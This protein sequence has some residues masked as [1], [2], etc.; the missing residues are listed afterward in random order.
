MTDQGFA[1]YGDKTKEEIN[2]TLYCP[3]KWAKNIENI[4]LSNSSQNA[5]YQ[6][7]QN[8]TMIPNP[9]KKLRN[10]PQKAILQTVLLLVFT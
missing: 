9:K 1:I 2:D 4:F 10:N 6:K 7:A 8:F 5:G 3:Q